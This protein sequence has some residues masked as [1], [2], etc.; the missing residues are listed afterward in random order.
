MEPLTLPLI[1]VTSPYI[2]NTLSDRRFTETKRLFAWA[3]RFKYTSKFSGEVQ[4]IAK[5]GLSEIWNK[6]VT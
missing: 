6:A 2:H 3:M 4:G 5:N 1:C